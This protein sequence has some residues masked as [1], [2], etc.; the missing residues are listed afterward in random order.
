V[1]ARLSDAC[2]QLRRGLLVDGLAVNSGKG[3][4]LASDADWKFVVS[5]VPFNPAL[6][7]VIE[8]GIRWQHTGWGQNT[9][10]RIAAGFANYWAGHPAEQDSF[11]AWCDRHGM[12]N[13]I[14]ISGD[15][16]HNAL[17]DGTNSFYPELNASGLSVAGTHLG[18]AMRWT[19][20]LTGGFAYRKGVW[21]AGGNGLGN[22]N[23]GNGYGRVS[24]FG[25]EAVLLEIVDENGEVLAA[26]RIPWQAPRTP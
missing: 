26:A 10:M 22:R 5:G 8:T 11:L 14:F 21:N 1:A 4:V 20:I 23:H 17:D 12:N 19:G 2:A 3:V 7:R 18:T 25:R 6:R 16:H 15:T 9:G 13:I 24:V